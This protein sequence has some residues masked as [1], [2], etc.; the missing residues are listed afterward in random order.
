MIYY[1]ADIPIAVWVIAF[2]WP[3]LL[4]TLHELVKRQ[5]VK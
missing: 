2:L 3:L 4:V 5:E 1:L